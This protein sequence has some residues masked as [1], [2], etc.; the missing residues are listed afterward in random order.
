LPRLALTN[1]PLA[2]TVGYADPM[3]VRRVFKA[4]Q[5]AVKPLPVGAQ[6]HDTRGLRLASALAALDTGR[7]AIRCLSRRSRRLPVRAR[8]NRQ[9]EME[10]LV[11]MLEGMGLRTGVDIDRFRGS[12]DPGAFVAG[13][14]APRSNCQGQTA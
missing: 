1:Y 9:I 14:D 7:H 4:V 13:R 5:G 11:F 2:D 3:S 12:G 8:R 10:D 6:F